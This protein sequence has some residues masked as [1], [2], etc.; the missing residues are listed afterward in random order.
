MTKSRLIIYVWPLLFILRASL[1]AA[2]VPNNPADAGGTQ[3]LGDAGGTVIDG[4]MGNPAIVGLD[5]PP[6]GGFSLLPVSVA[7]WSDKFAPPFNKRLLMLPF[8][9]PRSLANYMTVFMRESF[10]L[11]NALTPEE[12]SAKLTEDLRGGVGVHAGMRLSPFVFA[13]RGFGL[14]V[15]TFADADVRLS[16][17][18]LLPFFSDTAGLLVGDALDLSDT[19]LSAIWATEVAV[20]LG[21]STTIPFLRD[22]LKLDKGAA[23]VGVKLLLGHA[24]LN[25]SMRDS[26]S[27]SYDEVENRYKANAVM[28]VLSVGFGQRGGF[29]YDTG[30]PINGQGWGLD[31]GTV[32]YNKSHAFSVDV[33]DIGMI[34]WDGSKVRREVMNM[35]RDF[36][37]GDFKAGI[38]SLISFDFDTL[39]SENENYAMWL[40]AALNVGYAYNL[41]FD[42]DLG[43]FLGFL[44]VGVG[45][46]QRLVS[47][48]GGEFSL[49]PPSRFSGGVSFGLLSGYLPVRYGVVYGGPEGLASVIGVGLDAKYVS[50]DAYYKAVGSLAMRSKKGFEVAAGLSCRWGLKRGR[51]YV[52]DSQDKAAPEEQGW[53]LDSAPEP[54]LPDVWGFLPDIEGDTVYEPVELP[55]VIPPLPEPVPFVPPP[56]PLPLTPEPAQPPPEEPPTQRPLPASE[57]WPLPTPQDVDAMAVAQRA[58]NFS[59]GNAELTEGSYAPL[60]TVAN[61]LKRYPHIRY[62]VCG[63]TDSWGAELHNLLLSAE[64]AAVVK[65]YL[66]S[67]GA[68]DTSLV[69]IGYGQSM[70]I[71][72]N[73]TAVGRA[74]NRRVE[75]VPID[76]QEQ[77]DA[78]KRFELEMTKRLTDSVLD[79]KEWNGR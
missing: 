53:I 40:P 71:A 21:Y 16:G 24:Y 76:S 51:S 12:V 36:D 26:S 17:G 56:E 8:N 37:L 58:I 62:A 7:L 5:N 27:L 11:S 44:A 66:T 30:N 75:F 22:H 35:K 10:D 45:Y 25:A 20:K 78:L 29:R 64:R 34:L 33:R 39:T 3:S 65:H 59:P 72:D 67:R 6:K 2:S 18:F 38:D 74:L 63:H 9:M 32:F 79:K 54:P 23:G 60:E 28:D 46:N 69:A 15:S 49:S 57:Q 77:Y 48:Y 14:S 61:L 13:T 68:P 4:A 1:Q 52:K 47:G 43:V 73:N 19:R 31:L 41:R 55:S 50:L 42:G 70:P